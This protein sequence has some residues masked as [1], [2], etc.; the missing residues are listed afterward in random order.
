MAISCLALFIALGGGAYAISTKAPENS[1]NSK[2]I[3][4]NSVK[5][6][7]VKDGS[8]TGTDIDQ[9]T[10]SGGG[11][12]SGGPPSGPAGGDLTGNYP[13]P[14]IAPGAVGS[15]ALAAGSIHAGKLG[16]IV[17]VED[18]DSTAQGGTAQAQAF[19]PAGTQLISGGMFISSPY[20]APAS[21]GDFSPPGSW[22]VRANKVQNVDNADIE[23]VAYC[24]Q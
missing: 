4:D 11:G 9:S 3:I 10:L 12:G 16:T 20:S 21:F 7:D 2:A 23:A 6:A 24:L 15:S 14:Q 19:C 18:A 13:K 22:V 5:S 8:L 1:V 17:K